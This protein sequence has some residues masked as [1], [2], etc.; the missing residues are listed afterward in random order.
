MNAVERFL[1]GDT[2]PEVLEEVRARIERWMRDDRG[3]E[4]ARV[5][6]LGCRYSARMARR[7]ALL[8]QAATQLPPG[9]TNRPEAL[10]SALRAFLVRR[11]PRWRARGVPES[12]TELDKLLYQARL[13]D[14]LPETARRLRDIII[15]N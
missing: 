11:W 9:I 4:L 1:A 13:L 12:A 8:R 14:E 7:N 15:F 2:S 10:A 3:P 5:L 6:G